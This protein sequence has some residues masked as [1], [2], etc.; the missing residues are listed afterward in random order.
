MKKRKKKKNKGGLWFKVAVL[1]FAVHLEYKQFYVCGGV[2]QWFMSE[3]MQQTNL[4]WI[5]TAHLT[6]STHVGFN[7]SKTSTGSG[8]RLYTAWLP[9]PFWVVCQHLSRGAVPLIEVCSFYW[10]QSDFTDF[11]VGAFYFQNPFHW[12][13][14]YI[15]TM[16]KLWKAEKGSC[17][18]LQLLKN[19]HHGHCRNPS[20][21]RMQMP[22]WSCGT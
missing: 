3:L 20:S 4:D 14:K 16:E 22:F 11:T 9:V 8:K 13:Q 15:V 1:G 6:R 18:H 17:F 5:S 19:L 12:T 10:V 2:I 21:K 7:D